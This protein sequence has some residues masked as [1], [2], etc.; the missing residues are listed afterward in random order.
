MGIRSTAVSC[1]RSAP[2][3][4]AISSR[5]A[6]TQQRPAIAKL[7]QVHPAVPGNGLGQDLLIGGFDKFVHEPGGEGVF[8]PVALLCGGGAE[9]DEQVGFAGPGVPNQAEGL[10]FADP[11]PVARV[12]MVAGLMFGFASKSKSPSHLSRGKFAAFTRRIEERRSRS[13]HSASSNSARKP[14]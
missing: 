10:S 8:D 9:S 1:S 14:W 13:S 3:L 6:L 11:S 4:K 2:S 5:S 12:W 7:E